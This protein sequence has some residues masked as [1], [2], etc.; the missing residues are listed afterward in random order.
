MSESQR[1]L[2]MNSIRFAFIKK[3]RRRGNAKGE[4]KGELQ[5]ETSWTYEEGAV[6]PTQ[7]GDASIE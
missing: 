2:G 1:L 3:K 4:G 5:E 6:R 7:A